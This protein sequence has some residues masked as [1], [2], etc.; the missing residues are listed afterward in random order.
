MSLSDVSGHPWGFVLGTQTF[1][2][3]QRPH[4]METAG[5]AALPKLHRD[6]TSIKAARRLRCTNQYSEIEDSCKYAQLSTGPTGSKWLQPQVQRAWPTDA[7]HRATPA[8]AFEHLQ[9]ESKGCQIIS[10][11]SL[12]PSSG[13]LP[14]T[15]V[16]TNPQGHEY[17]PSQALES[18][19]PQNIT[20]MEPNEAASQDK[21]QLLHVN[22]LRR[23]AHCCAT[24]PHPRT[25]RTARIAVFLLVNQTML[26]II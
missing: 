10:Q 20:Q 4:Y 24:E 13:G 22:S 5:S 7:G 17:S 6:G 3:N 14:P 21:S 12:R 2:L 26:L 25:A 23:H 19:T 9:I 16:T 15:P 18:P 8:R 1:G 11:M